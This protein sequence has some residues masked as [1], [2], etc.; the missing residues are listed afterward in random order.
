[1]R[2]FAAGSGITPVLSIAKS[3]LEDEPNSTF[4]LVYGNKTEAD[5]IFHD[6]LHALTT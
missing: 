1:M 5:T 4:V 6:E 3:V 2:L